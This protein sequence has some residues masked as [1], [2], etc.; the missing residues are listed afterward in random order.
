MLLELVFQ[1]QKS[2]ISAGGAPLPSS[3]ISDFRAFPFPS[4]VGEG[5]YLVAI[6]LVAGFPPHLDILLQWS[7]R[8]DLCIYVF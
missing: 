8:H 2:N 7:I 5:R 6:S 1:L 4:L 3:G